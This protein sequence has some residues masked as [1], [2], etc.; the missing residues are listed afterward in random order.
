MESNVTVMF[1][2]NLWKT[3]EKV[4]KRQERFRKI[5]YENLR[6]INK[7]NKT[8]CRQK[9]RTKYYV[10]FSD[11]PG[12]ELVTSCLLTF[13]TWRRSFDI[14]YFWTCQTTIWHFFKRQMTSWHFSI[15]TRS[16][17]WIVRHS[18]MLKVTW[19][20]FDQSAKQLVVGRTT[21]TFV[22]FCSVV[23]GLQWTRDKWS[24]TP[25]LDVCPITEP[26]EHVFTVRVPF[27]LS[28]LVWSGILLIVW[29][30]HLWICSDVIKFR[31]TPPSFP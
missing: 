3:V 15:V 9:Q 4:T 5:T 18:I 14:K 30:A 17:P 16:W 2:I 23:V 22:G 13:F 11:R 12:I 26:L 28:Y 7:N 1:T 20:H 21:K 27:W 25:D 29:T 8:K 31:R 24:E 19:R 6:K 10:W